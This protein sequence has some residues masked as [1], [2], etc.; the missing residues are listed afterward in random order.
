M[1]PFIVTIGMLA[2][3]SA[4]WFS[5]PWNLTIPVEP[6]AY[7]AAKKARAISCAP[8]RS[9]PSILPADPGGMI[10]LPGWGQY[11]WPS[12]SGVDS[13]QFYFDQGIN[14]YYSFHIVESLAS[15]QKAAHLDPSSAMAHWGIALAY[16]PNINDVVYN[17][18]PLALQAARRADALSATR[19]P[20][21]KGLIKAMLARYSDDPSKTRRALDEAY[22]GAMKKLFEA[23]PGNPDA[24]TLYADAL[25]LLHPWDLYDHVQRPKAWTPELVATLEK[26][27]R[28]APEHPGANHYYIHA[29][30]ASANPGR[31]LASADK[32]GSL[33]PSV[34]H[35]VHM[36]SHI[37]IRTGMYD[38]GNMVNK[39]AIEGYRAYRQLMPSVENG[40]FIYLFHNIHMQ[41]T[42][43]MNGGAYREAADA[44][45]L[46]KQELPA[47]YLSGTPPEAE[48]LQYMYMSEL[49]TEIRFGHWDKILAMPMQP[50]SL[51]YA[52][53]LHAFGRSLAFS[54]LNRFSEARI[55]IGKMEKILASSDRLKKRMGAFNTAYAGGE[56][57]VAMAKG[58]LAEAE[59]RLSEAETWLEK[60]VQLE[61]QMVYD[62]PKDWL[63]PPRQYLGAA[64]LK[65]GKFGNAEAVFRKDLDFNPN[66]GWSLKGLEMALTAQN[67]QKEWRAYAAQSA[68]VRQNRD[69]N[70]LG[71]VF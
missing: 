24:G 7:I 37:Y 61:D 10:P 21:E 28:M 6:A 29:V 16:G 34:S 32:L 42:C 52:S 3:L 35:M 1:K 8:D 33:L 25:M 20:F 58:V 66:N 55:E 5:L 68:E 36:P 44:S 14:M 2:G 41:A 60:A 9:D 11:R 65:A 51:L 46:L 17:Y 31:A 18:S 70:P 45:A 69:F 43:A 67:R 22:A 19:T 47:E 50:D 57:A 13:A 40:A 39:S 4:L 26:V 48:Y 54:R 27:L 12:V 15:F 30:E 64:L 59:N 71:P 56:V 62:E 53:I 38:K 23:N 63:L 49:F